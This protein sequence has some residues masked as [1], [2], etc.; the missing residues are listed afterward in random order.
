M[1]ECDEFKKKILDFKG[2]QL[3]HNEQKRF[4][5][6]LKHCK[7]CQAEYKRLEKL[8]DILDKDEVIYP[9]EE[10]FEALK[11]K[12]RQRRIEF[13]RANIWRIARVLVP[14][15]AAAAIILFILNRPSETVEFTIPT[16]VL[17][18]DREIARLSLGG[19]INDTLISELSA[20][21]EGFSVELDES[22]DELT[23][24]EQTEFIQNLYEKYGDE[25]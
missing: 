21:E 14:T 15:F 4:S 2:N 6:H 22:I 11:T 16:S 8:Y 25:I 5:E 24:E 12:I 18:E 9:N 1:K 23:K 13:K 19:V 7:Q 17:L 3:H 10:F 20:V